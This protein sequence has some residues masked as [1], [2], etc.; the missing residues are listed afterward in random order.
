[1]ISKYLQEIKSNTEK[2]PYN[3]HDKQHPRQ[4]TIKYITRQK[5]LK[6]EFCHEQCQYKI[7]TNSKLVVSFFES[8][9]LT[10]KKT[11]NYMIVDIHTIS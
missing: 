3:K 7:V 8:P 6:I 1:M 9:S 4:L 10:A 11:Y 2:N 5:T